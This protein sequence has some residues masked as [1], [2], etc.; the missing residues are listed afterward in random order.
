MN[1]S[2]G[3]VAIARTPY[4]SKRTMGLESQTIRR[5]SAAHNLRGQVATEF[6]MYTTVFMFVAVAAFVVV[7]QVMR[8][9][10]PS[11]EN[12]I[13]KDTGDIFIT[14]ISL[15]VRSGDGFTYNYTFPRTILGRPYTLSFQPDK[16]NVILD[17]AGS[18]GNFS[19]SYPLPQY[20]YS[21]VTGNCMESKRTVDDTDYYIFNS[22]KCSN[23]LSLSNSGGILT[24]IHNEA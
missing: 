21:I 13:A 11:R 2:K 5:S 8:T 14:S 23:V 17:W 10:I 12:A 1:Q 16:G 15:A 6:L 4:C 19:Q 24:V 9:E 3:Q 22:T 18:Y 20:T 7:N